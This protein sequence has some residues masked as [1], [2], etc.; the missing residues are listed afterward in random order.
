MAYI[1]SLMEKS[2]V[3]IHKTAPIEFAPKVEVAAC[4]LEIQGK[5]LIL[6]RAGNLE[7]GKWGVPAGKLE[8]NESPLQAA[9]RELFEET[10]ISSSEVSQIQ[11]L[12][13]LYM[14]KP[15]I[16]YTY[17][18]FA[19]HLNEMPKVSLSAREHQNFTWASQEDLERIPLMAGAKEALDHYKIS[20][21][22][23]GKL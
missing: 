8:K 16:D 1:G 9:I 12:G 5:L 22:Q 19:F 7:T 10:G 13:M 20:L 15:E 14:R 3:E 17:H 4:Y 18:M 6:Q 23:S 2:P 11:D 21:E